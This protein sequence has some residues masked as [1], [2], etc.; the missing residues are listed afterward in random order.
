[1]TGR[2]QLIS[3]KGF[4]QE[5]KKFS[6]IIITITQISQ[7]KY[8]GDAHDVLEK[9]VTTLM[10]SNLPNTTLTSLPNRDYVGNLIKNKANMKNTFD[11]FFTNTSGDTHV[12]SDATG[13]SNWENATNLN[14]F[15][16]MRA[17]LGPFN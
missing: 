8:P 13:S 15:A 3:N 14:A 9:E 5:C 12:S 2:I 6:E 17:N 1:M 10:N 16:Y 11:K 7:Y 4:I